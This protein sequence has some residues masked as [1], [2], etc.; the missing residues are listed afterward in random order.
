M[1]SASVSLHGIG[2][3][4]DRQ[5]VSG[6]TRALV[7]D[8]A[9]VVERAV[10]L[11]THV[12]LGGRGGRGRGGASRVPKQAQIPGVQAFLLGAV[13]QRALRRKVAGPVVDFTALPTSVQAQPGSSVSFRIAQT[14][15]SRLKP[16][17]PLG[18]SSGPKLFTAELKYMVDGGLV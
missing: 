3:C 14:D 18:G 15:L 12:R 5:Q 17:Q 13:E 6:Q 7:R 9:Q 8:P 1:R 16:A 11:A 2:R 10:D 4:P